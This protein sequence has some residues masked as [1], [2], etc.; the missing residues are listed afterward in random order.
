MFQIA[1]TLSD[2]DKYLGVFYCLDPLFQ[3][4]MFLPVGI[5]S[6]KACTWCRIDGDMLAET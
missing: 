2:P 4:K 5:E 3:T 6:L 1:L